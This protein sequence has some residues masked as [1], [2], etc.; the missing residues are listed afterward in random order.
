[1]DQADQILQNIQKVADAIINMEV[2]AAH[3]VKTKKNLLQLL[4]YT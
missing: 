1:M 4:K 2:V 3:L